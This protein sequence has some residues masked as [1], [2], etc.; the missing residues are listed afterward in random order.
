MAA[1]A[2][3]KRRRREDGERAR[4]RLLDAAISVIARGGLSAASHRAVAVEA[5]LAPALTTYYFASKTEMISAAFDRF[6]DRGLESISG[7]WESAFEVL[8]RY[9]ASEENRENTIDQLTA[10]TTTYIFDDRLHQT[11]GVAFELAFL[12][13]SHLDGALREKVRHYRDGM[14]YT[15]EEFCRNAG[16]DHPATDASLLMG[17]ISRLEFEH[18]S[19]ATTLTI[20]NAEA[21]IRRLL[22]LV[23]PE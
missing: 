11:D 6:V 19:D 13:N 14:M 16:S 5:G 22:E 3:T 8:E 7:S 12:F 17:L 15:A 10:L 4:A 9:G 20:E 2:T 23:L 21:Q 18:L 1:D